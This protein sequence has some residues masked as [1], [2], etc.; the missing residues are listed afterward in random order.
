MLYIAI[1]S[2]SID[3]LPFPKSHNHD[4]GLPIDKSLNSTTREPHPVTEV[5]VVKSA[6]TCGVTLEETNIVKRT[7][8]RY[9]KG[10]VISIDVFLIK[11]NLKSKNVVIYICFNKI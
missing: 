1:G 8:K 6:V 2:L 3:V 10:L 4:V 9:L 11:R 7:R 5:I